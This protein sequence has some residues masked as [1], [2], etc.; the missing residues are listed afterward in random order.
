MKEKKQVFSSGEMQVE[1]PNDEN[2]VRYS[3]FAI[4]SHSAHE[5][6]IDFATILPGREGARVVSRIIMTPHNAKMF[7]T[8]LD[9]NIK[10]YEKQFSKIATD[11]IKG[12]TDIVQ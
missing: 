9:T 3:N 5:L 10:N 6:V 4:V 11:S 1:L 12:D 7:A 2:I 8:A